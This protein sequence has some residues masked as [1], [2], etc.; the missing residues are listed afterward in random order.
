MSI[1]TDLV[2]FLFIIEF[3][4]EILLLKVEATFFIFLLTSTVFDTSSFEAS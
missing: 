3:K 1:L 2:S 4:N